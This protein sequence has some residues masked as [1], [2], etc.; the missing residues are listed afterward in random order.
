[1]NSRLSSDATIVPL[2]FNQVGSSSQ[3]R[4]Y[5]LLT[6]ALLLQNTGACVYLNRMV[7]TILTNEIRSGTIGSTVLKTE[8]YVWNPG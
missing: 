1:M 6:V 2:D 5:I 7:Q 4:I 8:M 3:H